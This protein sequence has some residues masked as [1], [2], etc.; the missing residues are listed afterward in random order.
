[1]PFS[2]KTYSTW[3]LQG[4]K[5]SRLKKNTD[6]SIESKNELLKT[7]IA[8]KHIFNT[9]FRFDLVSFKYLLLNKTQKPPNDFKSLKWNRSRS[10]NSFFVKCLFKMILVNYSSDLEK[11]K[12]FWIF[13]FN[14]IISFFSLKVTCIFD[15][16]GTRWQLNEK[17]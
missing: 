15:L 5:W 14:F 6:H 10:F 17:G 3:L 16:N 2:F 8:L 11:I 4:R 7:S 1:M 13:F 9:I 12:K